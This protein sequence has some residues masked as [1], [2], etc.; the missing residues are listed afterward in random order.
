MSNNLC[1]KIQGEKDNIRKKMFQ[2]LYLYV[3][4]K[5]L[6]N[7]FH[8]TSLRGKYDSFRFLFLKNHI[9]QVNALYNQ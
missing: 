6:Y 5:F 3:N 7:I 2:L 8:S 9:L 4:P 1:V